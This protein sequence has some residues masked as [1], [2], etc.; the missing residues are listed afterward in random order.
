MILENRPW[1]Q[2][3]ERLRD[4]R[5]QRCRHLENERLID[6]QSDLQA[7]GMFF[8]T[9]GSLILFNLFFL[10]LPFTDTAAHIVPFFSFH[11]SS[12]DAGVNLT[13]SKSSHKKSKKEKKK[14]DKS[15]KR[16][17]KKSLAS[18]PLPALKGTT[19]LVNLIRILPG[20]LCALCGLH[21]V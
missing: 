10:C 21:A 11:T 5:D 4:H 15:K 6:L 1:I 9:R 2:K 18:Q 3:D 8:G 17:K 13:P 12:Y 16:S 19:V 14:K 7:V 20:I